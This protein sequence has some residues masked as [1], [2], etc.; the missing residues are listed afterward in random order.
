M[1]VPL[2]ILADDSFLV[3]FHVFKYR[4]TLGGPHIRLLVRLVS[5][6]VPSFHIPYSILLF[7]FL[8]LRLYCSHALG[9]LCGIHS[10]TPRAWEPRSPQSI[11]DDPL[12]FGL[13][14]SCIVVG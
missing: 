8:L 12:Y 1:N 10:D 6:H 13:V 4:A 5:A 7:L 11:V 3:F 14:G 2:T 9:I